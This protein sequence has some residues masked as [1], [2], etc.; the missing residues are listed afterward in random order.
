LS[1]QELQDEENIVFGNLQASYPEFKK[2]AKNNFLNLLVKAIASRV[3]SLKRL[4]N[5]FIET[6]TAIDSTDLDYRASY[7]GL[8]RLSAKKSAGNIFLTGEIGA[9][10]PVNSYF[11]D[12][13]YTNSLL[14]KISL[15]EATGQVLINNNVGVVTSDNINELPSGATITISINGIAYN[16]VKIYSSTETG[17]NFEFSNSNNLSGILPIKYKINCCFLNISSLETGE[18]SILGGNIEFNINQIITSVDDVAYITPQGITGGVDVESDTRFKMRW[19]LVRSGYIANFSEDFIKAFIYE[20]FSQVTR[21]FIRKASP[22]VGSV[23]IY[24]LFETRLNILPTAQEIFNIKQIIMQVAPISVSENN[25]FVNSA[26]K[27]AININYNNVIPNTITM[28]SAII[29]A[30]NLFFKSQNALGKDFSKE[31]L[32]IYLLANAKDLN[33]DKLTSINLMALNT[34]INETQISAVGSINA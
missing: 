24:P 4:A 2:N 31:E 25:V 34:V 20:N 15:F 29:D 10:I 32:F 23:E 22:Q 8:T 11:I 30:I 27:V 14:G 18:A 16:E 6:T 26:E 3:Y 33:N 1:K 7:Y 9:E 5:V 28:N 12:G 13:N 21:V 17:F 19:D